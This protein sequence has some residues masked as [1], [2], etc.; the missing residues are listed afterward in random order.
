MKRFSFFHNYF[1]VSFPCEM[2][3]MNSKHIC[4]VVF[5]NSLQFPES[6]GDVH[7]DTLI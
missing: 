2:S 6:K 4:L 5:F 1:S 3:D 7:M